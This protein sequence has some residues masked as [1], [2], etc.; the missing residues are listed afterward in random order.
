MKLVD[1]NETYE[2]MKNNPKDHKGFIA[3]DGFY[4]AEGVK[5]N[6]G[7]KTLY[8]KYKNEYCGEFNFNGKTF[9]FRNIANT[10]L[11]Q[12]CKETLTIIIDEVAKVTSINTKKIKKKHLESNE[13]VQHKLTDILYNL[14]QMVS[15]L[16]NT[17]SQTFDLMQII[18]GVFGVD[19]FSYSALLD[20]T[21]VT[22]LTVN[23]K[24]Y[25]EEQAIMKV[26]GIKREFSKK[27]GHM[28][29]LLILNEV[30]G[31]EITPTIYAQ[32]HK[33]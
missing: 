13:T 21:K 5:N 12:H 19:I 11:Q 1:R 17:L 28:Q 24:S 18:V 30:M 7:Y 3:I 14:Y 10:E 4:L 25:D 32:L 20:P 2:D 33:V 15:A 26:A 6:K 9:T 16:D 8:L 23:A 22:I 27:Y 29:S 31:F